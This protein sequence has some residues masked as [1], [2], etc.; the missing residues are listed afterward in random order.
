M[1]LKRKNLSNI[2]CK[3]R[4]GRHYLNKL[5]LTKPNPVDRKPV[6]TWHSMKV[7]DSGPAAAWI[8]LI[9]Y[10]ELL[11][12]K[13]QVCRSSFTVNP[14]TLLYLTLN[15]IFPYSH[16]IFC[17]DKYIFVKCIVKKVFFRFPYHNN[18]INYFFIIGSAPQ[19]LCLLYLYIWTPRFIIQQIYWVN[20]TPRFI[21]Q[22]KYCVNCL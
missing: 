17:L 1:N 19:Y 7:K 15:W 5:V 21:I 12:K 10:A 6:L 2:R 9:R 22:H 4:A 13:I 20:F 3:P 18:M 14:F 11:K 16:L 8:Y